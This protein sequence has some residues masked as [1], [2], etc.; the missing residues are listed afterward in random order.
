M[1]TRTL[2]LAFA[3]LI[4]A[5]S[6]GW[7]WRT[8]KTVHANEAALIPVVAK[9]AAVEA[10]MRRLAAQAQA[11]EKEQ[12]ELQAA[13]DAMRETKPLA[14]GTSASAPV[15]GKSAGMPGPDVKAMAGELI[16]RDP[17]LQ[18]L[19]LASRRVSLATIYGP[20]FRALNLTPAQS[21][22]FCDVV[23]RSLEQAQDLVAVMRAQGLSPTDP[24]VIKLRQQAESE[25]RAAQSELLGADGYAALQNYERVRDARSVVERFAGAAAL[26]DAALSAQQ[27]ERLIATIAGADQAYQAGG[28]AD[29]RKIDWTVV[30]ARAAEV[31]SPAQLAL[32]RRIEPLGGGPSR[33]MSQLSRQMDAARASGSETSAKPPGG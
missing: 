10:E 15:P 3:G 12:A 5:G 26:A 29:P 21:E 24:A 33:W 1:S 23:A 22:K 16:E 9:R 17:A 19:M 7:I 13:L 6:T 28:K 32:F 30:D 18:V 25:L 14:P 11:L 31:L 2:L 4:V 20:L 27:A 8:V